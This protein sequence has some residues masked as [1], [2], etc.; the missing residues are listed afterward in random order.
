[1]SEHFVETINDSLQS[2]AV[3]YA[4]ML[5]FA[6]SALLGLNPDGFESSAL[7]HTYAACPSASVV[8]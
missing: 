4:F 8:A 7:F 3:L 1:M 5:A 6:M 2:R